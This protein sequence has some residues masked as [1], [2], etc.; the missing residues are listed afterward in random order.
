MK[1][2]P[3]KLGLCPIGKFVFSHEDALRYKR[4]VAAKLTEWEVEF[5]DIEPAVPDGIVRAVEQVEPVVRH[6]R[7]HDVD[8]VFMPHCNFGTEHAVGLIGRDVGVPVLLWGP[9]D[10]A[11]LPD[12]TRL[13]DSLCG[14]L[15]SS[16]VLRKLGVP[17]NYV[18]N[19][20][21]EDPQLE[22]GVRRFQQVMSIVKGFRRMR[23]GVIGQRIGFFWTTI[24][25]E[26]DLL[27]RFG[28]E[29]VPVDMVDV[30]RDVKARAERDRAS[31]KEQLSALS[32]RVTFEG[33][34]DLSSLVNV[35]ALRD[36]M[37][38]IAEE[39]GLSGFAVQSFTSMCD[40]LGAMVEF[41]MAEVTEAGY[42]AACE[43]DVHGA[44]SCI[45]LQ[46]ASLDTEP[47][48]LADFTIR[49]P[50]DD[51]AVLLWH[52][53]APLALRKAGAPAS[54]GPHWILPGIPPGSCH[55]QLRDG[56]VT[57]ARF[58]GDGG[59]YRLAAGEGHTTDGPHTQNVY[60]WLQVDHW[61]RWERQLIA[62]PYIH[63]VGAA[64]GRYASALT[65]ACKYMPGLT[66]E[67]LGRGIE[68]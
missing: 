45:L 44:I 24:I 48:F 58:D 63:H 61:P 8:G 16:K 43:T 27:S 21:P 39:Q 5:V 46:R 55:W 54:L 1:R 29:L 15:A 3:V 51:N 50:Q 7:T 26:S 9:R 40:Q 65:E 17:F 60:A 62:G 19:C 67:P 18:E 32:Q 4:I 30:I 56:D 42:P 31:Y 68:S 34:D 47:T 64:Y 23:I 12:G 22:Q 10:E 52:C 49:H 36:E 13:R 57:V 66:A 59:E 14:L 35:L 37:L 6:L 25:D 38:R 2:N 28:V 41:A 33:F 53:S 11:P 20:R